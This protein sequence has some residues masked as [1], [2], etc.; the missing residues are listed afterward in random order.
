MLMEVTLR[1][2]NIGYGSAP[3]IPSEKLHHEHPQNYEFLMHELAG[4]F[5]GHL[6]N[7]DQNGYRTENEDTPNIFLNNKGNSIIFM[8]DSFTEGNQVEYK[9]TF[10]SRLASKLSMQ[11]LNLGVSS[12]SPI[13]YLLQVKNVVKKLKSR[14][15]VLQIYSNDF[16]NDVAYERSAVFENNKIVRID[17]GKNN[18]I[19]QVLRTSYVLRLLR[20]A[21][22]TVEMLMESKRSLLSDDV[23]D[24][25]K[26]FSIEQSVPSHQMKNTVN[27]IRD[28]HEELS[29]QGKQLVVFLIPNKSLSKINKCCENDQLYSRFRRELITQKIQFLDVGKY[30][31]SYKNQNILFFDKDIHL[32]REGHRLISDALLRELKV[33]SYLNNGEK[34]GN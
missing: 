16:V 34:D 12:Y 20:K 24:F 9:D 28:I 31:S 23:N 2:L 1:M 3:L 27:I 10:V 7:Y 26:T 33:S 5:G 14:L 8:G 6:V 19:T 4:E 13:L 25:E 15:V 17:G 29:S 22:L 32:T 11:T 30:F 21:Q 18:Y